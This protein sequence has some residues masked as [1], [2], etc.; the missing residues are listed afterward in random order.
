MPKLFI[1]L[2][3]D[4]HF[5]VKSVKLAMTLKKVSTMQPIMQDSPGNTRKRSSSLVTARNG[6][7]KRTRQDCLKTDTKLLETSAG[8][9]DVGEKT[10][11]KFEF[12]CSKCEKEFSR[13]DQLYTHEISHEVKSDFRNCKNL[14]LP[15]E[16]VVFYSDSES[17]E[18]S[19]D[20]KPL[21]IKTESHCDELSKVIDDPFF[22]YRMFQKIYWESVQKA[23][24]RGSTDI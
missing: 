11:I 10:K 3:P 2:F 14:K 20:N 22:L 15:F 5:P 19:D 13:E 16:N 23:S 9:A 12:S 18:G 7:V 8:K 4:S 6:R 21:E 1:C 17:E 24:Q